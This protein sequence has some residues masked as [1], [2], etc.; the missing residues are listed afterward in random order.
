MTATGALKDARFWSAE[1]PYLYDVYTILKVDGKVVD[2]NRLETGFRKAE[3]KGGAGTGGVYL[4]DKF[5]YLKGFAQRS[6]DEWAGARR[7]LSRLD[8]RLHRQT[9]PRLPRQLH[10]LDA[11]LA[12]EGG[13]G[14]A[15]RVSA[16][17]KSARPATRSAM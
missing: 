4:N 5:V 10:A 9:D 14:C 6:S 13:C 7:R 15:A 1:D 8:A 2:V 11:R 3:F 12:A 17:F 16:S